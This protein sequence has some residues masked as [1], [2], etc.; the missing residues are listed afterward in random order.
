MI[1][2]SIL[3]LVGGSPSVWISS[4]AFFQFLLLAGYAYSA[5]GSTCLSAKEQSLVQILL[6]SVCLFMVI[7]IKLI[8]SQ[9]D[10]SIKPELWVI[11]TLAFSIGLP[12][13]ILASNSTLIQRWYH[14]TFQSSPYY[15]FA[16]SNTGSILGLLSYPF[17]IERM[18]TLQNQ[19]T[20]WGTLFK[21][22]SILLFIAIFFTFKSKTDSNKKSL[23][24]NL[25]KKDAFTVLM[26]GFIPSALF[27][28][29]TLFTSTDITPFP[30]MWIIPLSIYLISFIVAFSN[31]G[32]IFVRISQA[33]HPFAFFLM[34]GMSVFFT[35]TL[36]GRE[37]Y[38]IKAIL[39][40]SSLFIICLSCQGKAFNKKPKPEYLT[41]YYLWLAIGGALGGALNITAPYIF[42]SIAEY[43]LIIL[44]SLYA[45]LNFKNKSKKSYLKYIPFNN[46]FPLIWIIITVIAVLT[47]FH[48]ENAKTK[49][50]QLFKERNFFGVSEV[51]KDHESDMIVYQHGNI[52]HGLQKEKHGTRKIA[53]T[54]YRPVFNIVE[55]LP[56]YFHNKPFG[57]IG[58]GGGIFACLAKAGQQL[59]F[60]EIDPAVIK[61]AQNPK[62]F[63]YLRDCPAKVNLIQGDG[64]LEIKK[65]P[66]GKYSIIVV[67]AFSSDAIP[68]HLIT[69]EAVELYFKKLDKKNGIL[70]IHIS[71]RYFDYKGVITTIAKE[72]NLR[73]RY[74]KSTSGSEN[75][76]DYSS[77][78]VILTP[79]GSRWDRELRGEARRI[80]T[81]EFKSELW[82]DDYS[83]ILSIRK[84]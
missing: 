51:Y 57:L 13:F 7:P 75:K 55:V 42:D 6:V 22:F 38:L 12:Y 63:S 20:L 23:A 76:A 27:L 2:K 61:I 40:F 9:L 45:I 60:F 37:F 14:R 69:K 3:P 28:S 18:L 73:V 17:V 84:R 11:T 62:Y 59:D 48:L 4:I 79:N 26:L 43:Y 19:M 80:T 65:Q 8:T 81:K 52:V 50:T 30:L 78:W 5:F 16:V 49:K 46:V 56:D 44:L 35:S 67:D 21:V 41:S 29:T 31:K 83:N 25:G 66:N 64:R 71:S 74:I 10:I 82:T 47:S 33:L 72:L 68:T 15:L 58:L 54:Y 1:A 39:I 70:I 32:Q 53:H 36:G 34:I 24:K 77:D